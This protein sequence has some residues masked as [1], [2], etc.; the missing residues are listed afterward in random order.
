[1]EFIKKLGLCAEKFFSMMLYRRPNKPKPPVNKKKG[2]MKYYINDPNYP[3]LVEEVNSPVANG[4]QINVINLEAGNF[5]FTSPQGL[6][7]NVY[8][9]LCFGINFFNTRFSL[10]KWAVTNVLNVNPMAGF[11]ANAYY[12]REGLKFFYFTRNNQTVYTALSS[13]IVSHELGHALLD[14]IRPDLFSAASMEAWAFHES[15]GDIHAILCALHHPKVVDYAWEQTGGDLRKSNIVSRVAEQF[16]IA[17]GKNLGLRDGANNYKYVNPASLPAKPNSPDALAREPHSFS[18]IM[19]GAFYE[20][21]CSLVEKL[22]KT[23]ASVSLAAD[24]LK[25]TFYPACLAAPSTSNFFEAFCSAWIKEDEKNGSKHKDVLL[26]VFQD[27]ALFKVKMMSVEDPDQN[28]KEKVEVQD[29]G[30]MRLEKCKLSC[31]VKDLFADSM[32]A[33][34][35]QSIADMKVHLAVDELYLNDDVV[36]WQNCCDPVKQAE[37]SAKELVEFIVEN[38]MF[39]DENHHM[40]FKNEDN[41]LTRKMFQCDCYRPN[42][43]FPGNP[44]YNKPYK[45]ENNSGCCTYGSCANL[46]KKTPESPVIKN[47]H[48]RYSKS[49]NNLSYSSKCNR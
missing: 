29:L 2:I 42:Y 4:L 1:M 14:A 18:Q 10:K 16:G 26:K 38:D 8:A 43:L 6:A 28:K 33:L 39:G 30:N 35:D 7:N 11:D 12:D 49:C 40:W 24:Y 15:F 22:G 17:L 20:V 47:C 34:S 21:F 27:R 9:I 31:T 46:Q 48:V 13:D 36:S 41:Y 5:E 19:T 23:K 32:S 44:E 45:P 37:T 25:Q 3:Q